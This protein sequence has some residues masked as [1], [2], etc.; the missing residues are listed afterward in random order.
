MARYISGIRQTVRQLLRDEFAEGIAQDWQDDEIDIH[1][2]QIREEISQVSPNEVIEVLPTIANSKILDITAIKDLISI[3]KLEYPTGNNP[4]DFRNAI[5]VDNTTVEIDVTSEPDTTGTT[6]TL[7]GTVTFVSGSA[8][9]TGSGTAF[10][11]EL[12]AGD[13]I[14]KSTG[15][16]WYRIYSIESATALTLAEPCRAVDTGADTV[17]VTAY[18][19]E[20]V[21]LYCSKLHILTDSESTMKAHQEKVLIDGAVASTAISYIGNLRTQ[22][23]EAT[24]R[25]TA[26]NTAIDSTKDMITRAIGDL[27]TGRGKIDDKR[28]TAI[29]AVDS[30]TA[31]VNQSL[32]DLELGRTFINKVNYGGSPEADYGN[33]AAKE[34]QEAA[35]ILQEARAYMSLH[36]TASGFG[37]YASRELSIVNGAI[38]QAG[39]YTRELGSRLSIADVINS[40]Q[41]WANN[42][43]AL[44]RR[45]LA[46][47]EV[48]PVWKEYPKD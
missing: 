4:R 29:D 37:E 32:M 14:R 20:A 45:A 48:T 33:Y 35:T 46:K 5:M 42:K 22:V 9:I 2:G 24:S 11:T 13:H 8:A 31:R 10:T 7:T 25:V 17:S 23:R 30:V 34:L 12:E 3:D 43:Y 41:T 28:E 16:R 36:S 6:S 38:T 47:I 1:I 18:L 39:G 27:N 44:Y 15:T 19:T 21:Y 26:I 40:Y